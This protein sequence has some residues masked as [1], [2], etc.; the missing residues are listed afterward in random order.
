MF[1]S[2]HRVSAVLGLCTVDLRVADMECDKCGLLCF[3]CDRTR[4]HHQ[5]K[6]QGQAEHHRVV[7]Q[8]HSAQPPVAST[9]DALL[10]QRPV[11]L[12]SPAVS[13]LSLAASSATLA[14]ATVP[15]L[16]DNTAESFRGSSARRSQRLRFTRGAPSLLWASY[17]NKVELS[18]VQL[19]E[20]DG[21][22][23]APLDEALPLRVDLLIDRATHAPHGF[24]DIAGL[25]VE[26]S[27][28][29]IPPGLSSC[30][31][32]FRVGKVFRNF[33]GLTPESSA[34]FVIR[35]SAADARMPIEPAMSNAF[36]V[37]SKPPTKSRGG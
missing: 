8:P 10:P 7:L 11:L 12:A 20:W 13:L 16:E 34:G 27:H 5:G 15:M 3:E 1:S 2:D 23:A 17:P 28:L 14:T 4:H 33:K 24:N 26:P 19:E 32:T 18:E 37:R 29:C 22:P 21:S 36:D 35:V 31:F 30:Q 25:V 9:L 6:R